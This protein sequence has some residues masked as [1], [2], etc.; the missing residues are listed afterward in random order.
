MNWKH[1]HS[2]P[3]N[4]NPSATYRSW[5]SMIT[6]CYYPSRQSYYLYGGRGITVCERWKDFR[7]FLADM[8][9]RPEGKTIDRVDNYGNYEPENCRWATA[10]EQAQNARYYAG[11][12]F[13]KA[14]TTCPKGHPY[15]GD[16]LWVDKNGWR[17][18]KTC[19]RERHR[20]SAKADK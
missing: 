18:C 20:K 2:R 16:N 15:A 7:N 13:N 19:N 3:E 10:K 17:F 5:W 9:E 12:E 8:G 6:R 4:G 11:A 1:G 14:K